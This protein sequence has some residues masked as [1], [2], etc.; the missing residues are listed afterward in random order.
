[1]EQEILVAYGLNRMRIYPTYQGY[2]W[3][4]YEYD[5]KKIPKI[6]LDLPKEVCKEVENCVCTFS[7]A[8]QILEPDDI[9]YPV[10][11]LEYEEQ[12]QNYHIF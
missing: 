3:K 8:S 10:T 7:L 4:G 6:A 1:M 2:E 11:L 9:Y 12:S 5:T